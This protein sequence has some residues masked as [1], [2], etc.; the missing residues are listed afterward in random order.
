MTK[1]F[2]FRSIAVVAL[3]GVI[4]CSAP[5]QPTSPPTQAA[6]KPALTPA[7]APTAA[8]TSSVA[9]SPVA[10]GGSP[11]P[12]GKPAA[13]APSPSPAAARGRWTFDNDPV[14]GL[15]NGSQSFSGQWAVRAEAD[16]PSQPNALC[17]T[18]TAEFPAIELD[19]K[20]YADVTL[21]TRFK[22]ISGKEDQAGGLIFRVQDKDNYYILRANALEDNVNFYIYRGGRRSALRGADAHVA[23]G[24]WQEL[25]VE[26]QGNQFRGFLN[27]QQV[28]DSSDDSYQSGGIGLWTK[29][30]S[31]TCF[32]DVEVTE[33]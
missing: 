12:A 4:A 18:G 9:A 22:P 21:T 13:T 11:S 23:A 16:A 17:Q 6:T 31:V 29:A 1:M 19:M 15:P 20:P 5:A 7:A 26:V 2:V 28:T 14:G 25:R 27:G 3:L 30:D 10:T 32:D 8:V 33:R 24:S